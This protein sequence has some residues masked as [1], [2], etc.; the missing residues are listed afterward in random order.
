MWIASTRRG[1]ILVVDRRWLRRGRA[2]GVVLDERLRSGNLVH[3]HIIVGPNDC[4]L[5]LRFLV[6]RRHDEPVILGTDA[7]VHL[8]RYPHSLAAA[9]FLA[10]FAEELD[11]AIL[12]PR[13]RPMPEMLNPL[14]HLAEQ[15]FVARLPD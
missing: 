11:R 5:E 7:L 2:A 8:Q 10:T 12:R 6:P 13:L 15:S 4:A 1:G 9:A 14:I 3:D